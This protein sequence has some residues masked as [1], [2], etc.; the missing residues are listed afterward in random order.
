[1]GN[2]ELKHLRQQLLAVNVQL[3]MMQKRQAT[4]LAERRV[5]RKLESVNEAVNQAMSVYAELTNRS[6]ELAHDVLSDANS[7]KWCERL[8]EALAA[9]AKTMG[10]T[11][12]KTS[13]VL[14]QL[15]V[16]SD[17]TTFS[18]LEILLATLA[19]DAKKT[20]REMHRLHSIAC[21]ALASGSASIAEF[22]QKCTEDKRHSLVLW[23]IS[24][25]VL[26]VPVVFTLGY[27]L[28]LLTAVITPGEPNPTLM[29]LHWFWWLILIGITAGLAHRVTEVFERLCSMP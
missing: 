3:A 15:S 22:E 26:G 10:K 8:A 20:G 4:A 23:W 24:F 1:V 13:D 2:D 5:Q 19:N 18:K 7:G 29:Q 12:Q 14:R 6:S 21:K 16:T 25:C 27:A 11:A 17:R 9:Q 28:L